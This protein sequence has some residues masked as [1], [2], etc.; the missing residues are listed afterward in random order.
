MQKFHTAFPKDSL[1]TFTDF[2]C[3]L[4]LEPDGVVRVISDS[5]SNIQQEYMNIKRCSMLLLY[6]TLDLYYR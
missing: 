6:K 2:S 3:I 1:P 5:S 4:H